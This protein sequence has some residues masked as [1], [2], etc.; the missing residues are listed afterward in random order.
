M[1]QVDLKDLVI[2]IR[3]IELEAQHILGILAQPDIIIADFPAPEKK[4]RKKRVKKGMG[5]YSD[6]SWSSASEV[7]T[8]VNQSGEQG[9]A[10]DKPK[11]GRRGRKVK[12]PFGEPKLRE[13]ETPI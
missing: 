7:V 6:P 4:V 12:S 5:A 13:G 8:P 2:R 3:A 1:K 10:S 11:R 9:D